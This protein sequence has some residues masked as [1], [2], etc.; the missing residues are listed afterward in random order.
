MSPEISAKLS[1][2]NSFRFP[3]D[4]LFR[5]FIVYRIWLLENLS[6]LHAGIVDS[7][8]NFM[9]KT[10]PSISRSNRISSE[11]LPDCWLRLAKAPRITRKRKKKKTA[12]RSLT[13]FK[14]HARL[15]LATRCCSFRNTGI[16]RSGDHTL[17]RIFA[18]QRSIVSANVI[19]GH[20]LPAQWKVRNFQQRWLTSMCPL[21]PDC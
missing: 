6:K 10:G 2:F 8:V 16:H 7:K 3:R 18:A 20:W 14:A 4:F 19:K 5:P 21:L 11:P 1:P 15:R 13:Y 17:T 9:K 12:N